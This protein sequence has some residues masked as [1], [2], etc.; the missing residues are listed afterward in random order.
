M[1]NIININTRRKFSFIEVI[2]KLNIDDTLSFVSKGYLYFKR[3]DKFLRVRLKHDIDNLNEAEIIKLNEE[4]TNSEYYMSDYFVS[5]HVIEISLKD[6]PESLLEEKH[7]LLCLDDYWFSVK[8]EDDELVIICVDSN[9][10]ELELTEEEL[11]KILAD[12]FFT[13][14]ISGCWYIVNEDE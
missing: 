11:D 14:I 2:E 1:E 8:K 9:L 4:I 12:N 13:A 10:N 6:V 5:K 3:K 7:V